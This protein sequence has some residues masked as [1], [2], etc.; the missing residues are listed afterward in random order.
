[1]LATD[2]YVK[3]KYRIKRY[4]NT[5]P[6]NE[7]I[8]YCFQNPPYKF[9]WTKKTVSVAEGSSETTTTGYIENYKN[10]S[11]DIRNQLD[12]EVK[13]VQIILTGIDNDICSTVDTCPNACETWKAIKK[14]KQG[15]LINVQDL[16]TNLYWEFRKF[17]SRDVCNNPLFQP[18]IPLRPYLWELHGESLE[19]YYSRSQQ[20][21]TRNRGKA[22][23]NSPPPTYDQKPKMVAKADALS[24]EKKINELM[25][26]ISLSFKKIYKPTNNN[27][28]T[29]SNTSRAHQ[30][31][32]L[33]INKGIGYDN[34]RVVNVARAKKNVGTQV[35]Q[36]YGIQCY[37]CKEYRHVEKECHKSKRAKDVAY[38]KEKIIFY[39]QEEAE[40][41]LSARKAIVNSSP[42]TY[43]QETKMAA[44]DDALSKEKEI[45]KLMALSSL[46]FKKIYKPTNNSLRTLSNTSRAH[47]DN[48]IRINRGIGYDNER[49][50]NVAWARENVGTQVVQQSRIQC[51]NCKEYRHVQKECQKSKR[52]KDAAYH[53]EKMLLCKQKEAGIQVSDGQAD[54]RDDADDEPKDQEL[55]AHY[56]Y[57]EKIQEREHPE[58]PESVNDTYLEEQGD[59]NIT[60]DSLDMS[61]NGETVDDDDLA[62][63]R[64][65]LA[66][67]VEK[68]KCEINDNKNRN[69]ILKS[70]NKTLIDKLKGSSSRL[71]ISFK[72]VKDQVA[73]KKVKKSFENADS[74][75]RVE[76][77]PSKN[78]YPIKVVLSFHKEFLVFSSLSRKVNDGLLQRSSV[79]E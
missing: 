78:K 3:W 33:R 38:H 7:L 28:K 72:I 73:Q 6:N 32:T 51:Y 13:A 57:M 22:I 40:I 54:W 11:Q 76:L 48:T 71:K 65:L 21:A 67:L 27:L 19:S 53:K 37:N 68:L 36:Q 70:S 15:E 50:V 59:T 63:E 41:Q 14:L 46:S 17:T 55:E 44:K 25:A 49:V 69:K 18:F 45:D 31:N 8:Y 26:L 74:C 24:K 16:E 2:N 47:Q 29:L 35:V 43:D 77:I 30:D 4:I 34:Q 62:K 23:V 79:Q 42:P 5:K 75:S 66:S 39:K 10:V 9:Q 56:L 12:A 61:N 60:I 20:A 52:A 64:D 58:Q 1:M